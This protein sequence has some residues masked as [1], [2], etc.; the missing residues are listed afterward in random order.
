MPGVRRPSESESTPTR[1]LP[2]NELVVTMPTRS[3]QENIYIRRINAVIDHVRDNLNDDLSLDT[4][5][6]V[7]CFSPFHF[8]VFS[9]RSPEK[10]S[11]RW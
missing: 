3:A 4:L 10:P 7:A 8:T 1:Q 2:E 11:T 5:A 6:R 9:N